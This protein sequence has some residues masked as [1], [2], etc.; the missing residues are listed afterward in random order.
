MGD[1]KRGNA[2]EG[3][4]VR[5]EAGGGVGGVGGGFPF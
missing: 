5:W 1:V 3:A 2:R 4:R